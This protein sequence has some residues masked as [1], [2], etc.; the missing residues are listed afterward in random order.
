MAIYTTRNC[1]N[2][3]QAKAAM[4][5]WGIPFQELDIEK[6]QRAAKEFARQQVRT[7]PLITIGE[8]VLKGYDVRR[9]KTLLSNSGFQLRRD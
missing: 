8:R 3:R 4:K 2:C 1:P 5:Q 6:N 9:L 7:V